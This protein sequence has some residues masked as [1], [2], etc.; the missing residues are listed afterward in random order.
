MAY[1][2]PGSYEEMPP[3]LI[4]ELK[5]DRR[6]C[7]GN[8][9]NSSLFLWQGLHPA[10]RA[11][12]MT[13]VMTYVSAPLWFLSL[14]LSTAFIVVQTVIG[15]R[16]FVQPRQL[17]PV[18]PEW[19]VNAAIGFVIGT[20]VV[21][22]TPKILGGLLVVVRGA[23][24]FGGALAVGLSILLEIVF[25]AL[26]A[27]IRMLFHTQFVVAALTGLGVHWKS[28]PREDAETTWGEGVRRHGVHALLG[29]AWA[30]AVYWMDSSYTWWL[31]LP[32]VGAL[33][34]SVP[35][36]VYSS[37]VSLGRALRRA[38]LLAIPE[39]TRPPEELQAVHARTARS[40]ALP[41]FVD[42]VVN[43]RVNAIACAVSC[44]HA[45]LSPRAQ[46]RR[47]RAV[48][49]AVKGGPRA[50]TERQKLFFLTDALALSQLHFE[51]WTSPTAH[52]IWLV[53]CLPGG[54]ADR[55]ALLPAS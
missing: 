55:A 12:F 25:S 52:P 54:R 48:A 26:L 41:G 43:P 18:W 33:A 40:E 10:H 46:A 27:P 14:T 24:G 3:N 21:L 32:V 53:A 16:Y 44:P 8:L 19:D 23:R 7:Q 49:A 28:P 2:L 31:L 22:F 1:D 11:V 39:E 35:I 38:R 20:A 42:A 29:A 34:L 51:I 9:I 30:A 15:P 5:R 4:D 36:S 37:R 47:Q 45:R 50:L 13:G 6:W 17:F